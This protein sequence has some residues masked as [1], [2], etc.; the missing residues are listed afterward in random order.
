[1]QAGR[2]RKSPTPLYRHRFDSDVVHFRTDCP[3][4]PA[5]RYVVLPGLPSGGK[6]CPHCQTMSSARAAAGNNS[7]P[8][9]SQAHPGRQAQAAAVG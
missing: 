2:R 5:T 3:H 7:A 4:W 1:M 8:A 9:A 6:V